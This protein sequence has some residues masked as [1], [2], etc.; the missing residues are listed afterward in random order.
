MSERRRGVDVPDQQGGAWRL[1]AH[2]QLL[3]RE[4]KFTESYPYL[5]VPWVNL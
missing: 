1:G 3:Y 2:R 5:L 4:R